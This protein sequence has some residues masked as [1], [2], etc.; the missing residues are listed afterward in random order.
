[1]EPVEDDD[2]DLLADPALAVKDESLRNVVPVW[3]EAPQ[4]PDPLSFAQVALGYRVPKADA[5]ADVEL[6]GPVGENRI[7][8]ELLFCHLS[9]L[10]NWKL[11]PMRR[12]YSLSNASF[13][14]CDMSVRL[15][16]RKSR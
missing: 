16:L 7:D 14:I 8:I 11:H 13:T 15:A 12:Y 4:E 2:V 9:P 1:M 3:Q 5:Q 6:I 10:G